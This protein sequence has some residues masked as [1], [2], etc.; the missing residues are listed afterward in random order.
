MQKHIE[1]KH[2]ERN[3]RIHRRKNRKKPKKT[4]KTAHAVYGVA[5]FVS[6][7]VVDQSVERLNG[8]PP[9]RGVSPNRVNQ[10]THCSNK[11]AIRTQFFSTNCT[12]TEWWQRLAV[13]QQAQPE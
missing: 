8:L 13:M 1:R 9:G 3:I 5:D 10:L 11:S 7:H 4:E 2:I 12:C 6:R